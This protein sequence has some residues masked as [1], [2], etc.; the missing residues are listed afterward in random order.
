[1]T[2]RPAGA[3][4]LTDSDQPAACD[5]H[6]CIG[7]AAGTG[8]CNRTEVRS[9]IETVETL[10]SIVDKGGGI[11]TYSERTAAVFMY[12]GSGAER[13]G[14]KIARRVTG[15]GTNDHSASLLSGARLNPNDAIVHDTGLLQTEASDS[16]LLR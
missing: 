4:I 5:V 8:R 9:R 12:T 1:M 14:Q 16:D 3:V 15:A 10:I 7:V 13:L 2:V 6:A 11:A